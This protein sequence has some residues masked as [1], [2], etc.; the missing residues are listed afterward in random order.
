MLC[1]YVFKIILDNFGFYLLF[2][3]F[4]FLSFVKF[5]GKLFYLINEKKVD[6]CII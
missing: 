3:C 5:Y 4:V 1:Y 2:V 6:I